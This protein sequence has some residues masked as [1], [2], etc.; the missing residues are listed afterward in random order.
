MSRQAIL[1]YQTPDGREEEQPL[2]LNHESSI[3]R[4]PHCTVTVSQP[5]VSRKHA[6]L[7]WDGQSCVVEDLHSSNGTYVNNQRITRSAL[8]DGDELRC[9]DFRLRYVEREA[10]APVATP[11]PGPKPTPLKVVGK[12]RPP[13]NPQGSGLAAGR[14]TIQPRRSLTPS[15]SDPASSAPV[16]TLQSAWRRR[17]VRCAEKLLLHKLP[18]RNLIDLPAQ[19]YT[20]RR[21]GRRQRSG[22]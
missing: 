19:T 1:V 15:G 3:G 18:S 2:A 11:E 12:L 4:H 5:S 20:A 10:A 22:P 7:E 14:K 6:R 8:R 21:S 16:T 17:P 9:G 13:T